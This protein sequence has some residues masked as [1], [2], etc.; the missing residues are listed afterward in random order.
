MTTTYLRAFTRE[1]LEAMTDEEYCKP[2]ETDHLAAL[3]RPVNGEALVMPTACVVWEDRASALGLP[4]KGER[5]E[6]DREA[7]M[8]GVLAT[9]VAAGIMTPERANQ[10]AFLTSV[11]RLGDYMDKQAALYPE[12]VA[13]A[14]AAVQARANG[15]AAEAREKAL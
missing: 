3:R 2:L 4:K 15:L 6:K 11:G 9:L 10:L 13:Q 12:R 14:A 1:Q 5:R 8:Q 7:Y